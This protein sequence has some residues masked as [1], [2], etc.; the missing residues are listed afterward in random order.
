VAA[1]RSRQRVEVRIE[2]VERVARP[3]RQVNRRLERL[4]GPIRR[5]RAGFAAIDRES[6]FRNLRRASGQLLR[7]VARVAAVV[8]GAGLAVGL[9]TRRQAEAADAIAKVS[10]RV[11]FTVRGYQSIRF[12]ADRS[13][14]S[15]EILNSSLVAFANRLGKARAGTGGLFNILRRVNPELL[16]QLRTTEDNEEAFRLFVNEIGRLPNAAQ[17]AALASAGFSRAGVPLVNLANVGAEGIA[18][19]E[20]RFRA[21]GGGVTE[22]AARQGESV[23]DAITDLRAAASSLA[24]QVATDLFPVIRDLSLQLTE[25]IANNRELIRTEISGFLRN[26]V[27]GTVALARVLRQV[28]PPV[29]EFVQR[30]GGLRTLAIAAGTV[31]TL[32]VVPA[33]AAV[34]AALTTTAGLVIAAVGG[35]G[36]AVSALVANWDELKSAGVDAV[37]AITSEVR[38]LAGLIPQSVIDF[39]GFGSAP[40]VSSLARAGGPS[41]IGGAASGLTEAAGGAAGRVDGT[42][43]IQVD[44]AGRVEGASLESTGDLE[45]APDAG[46][47]LLSAG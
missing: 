6:G 2:A 17:R 9:F 11:G 25:W 20:A 44:Q 5:I 10:D 15:Q 19:L 16:R 38:R 23:V 24:A 7:S 3:I 21:L 12:A 4:L 43:R 27:S 8:G 18:K 42:L 28:I 29:A 1:R 13:G 30:M 46:S 47:V 33:V 41:V 32:T 14:V 40:E 31:L 45:L 34:G 26:V 39:L 35:I 36:L 22:R 37:E